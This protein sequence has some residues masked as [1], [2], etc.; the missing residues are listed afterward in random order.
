MARKRTDIDIDDLVR[1]YIAGE[2]EQAIAASIGLGRPGVRRRLVEAGV[3][4]RDRGAAMAL[5]M[6]NATPEE[7]IA[8]ALAANAARRGAKASASE[9]SRKA[10][11]AERTLQKIRNG[12]IELAGLLSTRGMFADLQVAC[13]P[14]NIDLAFAPVAVEVHYAT[15][16]PMRSAHQRERVVYLANRGW[17]TLYVWRNPQR[18]VGYSDIAVDRVIAHVKL[19]QSD[20]SAVRE[21]R[22][23]RG[24]GEDAP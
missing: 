9:L 14:Y 19:A 2:S 1:R 13:G 10:V 8:L 12:E 23:I 3:T 7:R 20:P 17:R 11:T 22:V 4:P 5:R 6:A 24:T 18:D 16:H 21:Y 15:S